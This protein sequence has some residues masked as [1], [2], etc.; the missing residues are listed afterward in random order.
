MS[1]LVS[2]G[3]LSQQNI[4]G[5]Y[6]RASIYA[7]PA[8]YEPFGLSILEAALSGCTLVLGDIPSLRENWTDAAIF[9]PPDQPTELRDAINHM[10]HSGAGR[11]EFATR[12]QV[13]AR[14]FTS[15]RMASDYFRAY[16]LAAA[17]FRQRAAAGYEERETQC[18]SY[19]SA[20]Q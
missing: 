7:L 8:R 12:A 4:A 13:R 10:V 17:R 11:A 15:Q 19:S 3:Q 16:R 18:A 5:W 9:V 1:N 14:E 6:A 2:L 20:I